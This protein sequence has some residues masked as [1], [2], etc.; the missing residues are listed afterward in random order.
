MTILPYLRV[1]F[2][3]RYRQLYF[4]DDLTFVRNQIR[5]KKLQVMMSFSLRYDKFQNVLRADKMY[6]FIFDL[7]LRRPLFQNLQEETPH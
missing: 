7:R 6:L 5:P 1:I 4:L 3:T 2:P